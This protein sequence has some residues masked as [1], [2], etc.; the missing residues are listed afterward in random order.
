MIFRPDMIA[1][2]RER[3]KT[4]TR[5]AARVLRE[6]PLKL[7]PCRYRV[8]Q[9]YRAQPGRGKKGEVLI[10]ITDVHQEQLGE[11][12]QQD[13]RREG[14]R[15]VTQFRDR[16]EELHGDWEPE[17]WVWVI[18][19]AVGDL[20]DRF[21]HPRFLAASPGRVRYERGADGRQHIAETTEEHQDYTDHAHLG[22]PGEPE[23]LTPAQAEHYAKISRERFQRNG[24]EPLHGRVARIEAEII[25]LRAEVAR[26][27]SPRLT[28]QLQALERILGAMRAAA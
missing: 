7:E 19:F 5:R 10:T 1:L 4:Q 11:I 9:A 27:G 12:S 20:R 17:L 14:F 18:S 24:S 22:V 8:G 23:P 15:F 21:D 16:W 6:E 13:A 3:R 26:A 25:E 28:R 2:I